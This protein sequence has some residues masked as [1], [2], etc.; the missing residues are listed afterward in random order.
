MQ[1]F[2]GTTSGLGAR[3]RRKRAYTRPMRVDRNVSP[4]QIGAAIALRQAFDPWLIVDGALNALSERFPENDLKAVVVKVATFNALY[5]TNLYAIWR[6]AAHITEVVEQGKQESGVG[7]VEAIARFDDRYH[8]SFASKF[9]HFFHDPFVPIYDSYAALALGTIRGARR[10]Y[11]NDYVEY[12]EWVLEFSA[13]LGDSFTV[14]QID[15]FLWLAGMYGWYKQKGGAQLS[16]DINRLFE[17]D[18]SRTISLLEALL[19]PS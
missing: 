1:G 9:V 12:T 11:P 5:N 19:T 2:P 14:K 7:L 10:I 15:Q 3:L 18:D 8:K 16:V 13:H 4:S 6:M 17:T